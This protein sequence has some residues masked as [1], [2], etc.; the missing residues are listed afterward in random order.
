MLPALST[1]KD[2]FLKYLFLKAAKIIQLIKGS[3]NKVLQ[4]LQIAINDSI[5][6]IFNLTL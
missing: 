5:Y 4:F 3:K 2:I 1:H 6:S